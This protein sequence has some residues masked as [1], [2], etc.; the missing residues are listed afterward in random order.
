M[1]YHFQNALTVRT[2]DA[3]RG[4]TTQS[5]PT[6]SAF[7]S[8]ISP[9]RSTPTRANSG[10]TPIRHPVSGRTRRRSPNGSRA[11][12]KAVRQFSRS[13]PQFNDLARLAV[14]LRG[15]AGRRL[16]THLR[17]LH[18]VRYDRLTSDSGH[19]G[20]R[21][22]RPQRRYHGTSSR[23]VAAGAHQMFGSGPTCGFRRSRPG[24][25]IGSRPPIPI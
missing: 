19:I 8:A 14:T 11:W 22:F 24:V 6:C 1:N 21:I 13:E 10:G 9:K 3:T 20:G 15:V 23:S 16:L 17:S 4:S 7:S 18:P 12:R 2:L 25:P 5:F